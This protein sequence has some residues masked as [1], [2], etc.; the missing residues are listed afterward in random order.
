M[1]RFVKFIAVYDASYINSPITI[2]YIA[3]SFAEFVE[4]GEHVSDEEIE[5]YD[6]YGHDFEMN[7]DR[8]GEDYDDEFDLPRNAFVRRRLLVNGGG[9]RSA[10][11]IVASRRAMSNERE[12]MSK[13]FS[14]RPSAYASPHELRS[15]NYS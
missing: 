3:F 14:A 6:R 13:S 2:K 8:E 15:F 9:P 10:D 11:R 4:G 12:A 1:E 7:D 5:D